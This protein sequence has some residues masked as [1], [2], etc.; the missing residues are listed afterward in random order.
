MSTIPHYTDYVCSKCSKEVTREEAGRGK[1]VRK[2]VQF[3]A[4]GKN[5]RIVKSITVAFLCEDDLRNDEDYKREPH[6]G[7]GQ[8]SAGLERV[9]AAQA[10]VRSVGQ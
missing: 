8:R 1:L 9:R 2:I 6:R 3:V 10:A 5:P 7:P 4:F